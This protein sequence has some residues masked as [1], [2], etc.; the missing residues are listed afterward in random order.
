VQKLLMLMS[1]VRSSA[2]AD[3]NYGDGIFSMPE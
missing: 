2:D 3:G 1:F